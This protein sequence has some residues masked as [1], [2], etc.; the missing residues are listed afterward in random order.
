MQMPAPY[1]DFLH[2]IE[3]IHQRTGYQQVD[4]TELERAKG[5]AQKRVHADAK[6]KTRR[7]S[8]LTVAVLVVLILAIPVT[9]GFQFDSSIL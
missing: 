4:Q 6:K 2:D 8:A 9:I 5:R 3:E 1:M 7:I